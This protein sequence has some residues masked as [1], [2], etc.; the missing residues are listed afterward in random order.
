M[1]KTTRRTFLKQTGAV[2]GTLALGGLV[3]A[4]TFGTESATIPNYDT[5]TSLTSS[6]WG[7][8]YGE[9]RGG[10]LVRAIPF[11]DEQYPSPMTSGM[12]DLL[13]SPSRIRY[14]M[15]RKGFYQDRSKSDTTGRGAEPFVRVSWDEALGMVADEMERVKGAYGNKAIYGGSY[16]W[17]SAGR[18]HSASGIAAASARPVR[19]LHLVRQH[20]QRAR[21]PGDHTARAGRLPPGRVRLADHRRQQPARRLLRLQPAHQL[22][23]PLRRRR[24][25][26]RPVLALQAQG[27]GHAGRV[28]QPAAR[29]YRH[30]PGHRAH[31][32][33]AQHR[34]G[35]H[36]RAGL[37]PVRR[38][39]PRPGLPRQVHRRL[40]HLRQVPHRRERRPG[41]DA[42]VGRPH[43][44]GSGR[45]Y[46][47]PG[48]AHGRRP[49]RHHGRLLAA[50]RRA[51]RAARVGDDRPF[52]DAR[53]VRQGRGRRAGQ[54]PARPRRAYRRA[55]PA[56]PAC[57][58]SRTRSPTSCP[59]TCGST[60]SSTRAAPSTTTARGSPTTTSS[61]SCGPAA[62]RCTTPTTSTA[63]SRPGRSP[64]PSSSTTTTGPR[65]RST[66]TS[67][68]PRRRPWS[69]TTSPPA[70]TT[71]SR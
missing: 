11:K 15:V 50:A 62:T 29:G 39:A 68:S 58:R 22:R 56:C 30:L 40:R 60:S 70:A 35:A 53:P 71:S 2:A 63:S 34:H 66:P 10:R 6:H 69:A 52:G 21:P 23:H 14:P 64:R 41:E 59:S 25:Q 18:F 28:V 57:R 27:E 16:G 19:R 8:W 42:R 3:R 48:A 47:R 5:F 43:H 13:Y 36:A 55:R 51:R 67:C 9:V 37:R 26:L 32:H 61:S 54:L 33:P 24:L 38:E 17:N 44:G 31:R 12:P 20:L 4:Q 1:A 7:A 45:R 46:P 65:P 49:D